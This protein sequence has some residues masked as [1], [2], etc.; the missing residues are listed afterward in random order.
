MCIYTYKHTIFDKIIS[1]SIVVGELYKCSL[2]LT[3]M[4]W[5]TLLQKNKQMKIYLFTKVRRGKK[6]GHQWSNST[7]GY[8][9]RSD[10]LPQRVLSEILRFTGVPTNK[11]CLPIMM[12]HAVTLGLVCLAW[13]LGPLGWSNI[14]MDRSLF[15]ISVNDGLDSGSGDQ[16][17]SI[18]FLHSGSQRSGI[19][20]RRVFFTIPPEIT[21]HQSNKKP[22]LC[23]KHKFF[24]YF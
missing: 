6:F 15:V 17:S 21:I 2:R 9:Q 22:N 3:T 14:D 10:P 19:G 16:H 24:V 8:L 13:L 4:T 5:I 7:H 1:N 23:E 12:T 11:R 20:G 18:S